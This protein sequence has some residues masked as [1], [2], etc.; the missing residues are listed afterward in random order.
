MTTEIEHWASIV[1]SLDEDL[2]RAQY[3]IAIYSASRDSD[4]RVIKS[5]HTKLH[6]CPKD[7]SSHIVIFNHIDLINQQD[8]AL[9]ICRMMDT[10]KGTNSFAELAKIAKSKNSSLIAF[11]KAQYLTADVDPTHKHLQDKLVEEQTERIKRFLK[12][13]SNLRKSEQF[14]NIKHLRDEVLAHRSKRPRSSRAQIGMAIKCLKTL[15][16]LLSLAYLI[17][18]MTDYRTQTN[19]DYA[20]K[21]AEKFWHFLSKINK[22]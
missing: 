19:F 15:E 11:A 1:K 5:L 17:F 21:D 4:G 14:R 20:E 13:E 22:D 3:G 16:E 2:V 8:A 6:S 7:K 10:S 9:T 18:L 12:L